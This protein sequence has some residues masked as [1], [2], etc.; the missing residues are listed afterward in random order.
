[1]NQESKR[2]VAVEDL[3]RLKRAERP[4]AE[5]WT[6]FD[7]ELRAKQLAALLEKRPWW[8]TLP[9]VFTGFSR[10]SLP[11]GA[12]AALIVAFVAVKHERSPMATPAQSE[13]IALANP[14][15]ARVG[16]ISDVAPTGVA[17]ETEVDLNGARDAV[18]VTSP[19]ASPVSTSPSE[20][21][22]TR[23]LTLLEGASASPQ[24]ETPS[25]RYIASNLRAIQAAAPA[26]A[27]GLLGASHGFEERVLPARVPAVEP[28]A[29]MATPAERTR[30][31]YTT[32]MVASF[33]DQ[34]A[35]R[36][37]ERVA[38]RLSDERIYDSDIAHRIGAK[39]GGLNIK[40]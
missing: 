21:T 34:P 23:S 30:A 5:F 4:P 24:T 33:S 22:G 36:T 1:M 25:S 14:V 26:A 17:G 9:R 2:P 31:R 32:A 10:Y 15:S 7:Q 12:A 40:L 16:P 11:L 28:L 27:R 19:E 38:R 18:A 35:P 29:Q 13:M 37:S 39:S 6:R 3:L 20:F 8:R